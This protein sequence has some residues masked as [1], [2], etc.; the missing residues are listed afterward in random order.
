MIKQQRTLKRFKE[1]LT[2][3]GYPKV[4]LHIVF[5]ELPMLWEIAKYEGIVPAGMSYHLF[6]IIAQESYLKKLAE[7]MNKDTH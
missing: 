5:E 4:D 6:Q 1:H 2:P 3:F 7:F